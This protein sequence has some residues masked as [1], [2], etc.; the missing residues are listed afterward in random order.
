MAPTVKITVYIFTMPN[1]PIYYLV[2]LRFSQ[3][4]D[5]VV[6]LGEGSDLP[7][8]GDEV[9]HNAGAGWDDDRAV[10]VRVKFITKNRII[11]T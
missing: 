10:E 1:I 2:N 6:R 5:G 11:E 7:T 8:V 4:Y 9:L 3:L